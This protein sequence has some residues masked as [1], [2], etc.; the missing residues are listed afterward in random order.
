MY[1]KITKVKNT[2]EKTMKCEKKN[3]S[4]F[5]LWF[6]EWKS[7]TKDRNLDV[8]SLH[9]RWS[10]NIEANRIEKC[11][12]SLPTGRNDRLDLIPNDSAL[13]PIILPFSRD[14]STLATKI[15]KDL[16][17]KLKAADARLIT[18]FYKT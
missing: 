2:T 8:I 9:G 4:V 17:Q 16:N 6:V 11:N 10:W 7:T 14:S 12:T 3:V 1:L 13:I 5:N 18:A 15:I